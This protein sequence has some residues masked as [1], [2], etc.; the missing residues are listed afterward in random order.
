[1]LHRGLKPLFLSIPSKRFPEQ[2]LSGRR[3]LLR[4]LSLSSATERDV[5]LIHQLS[6][7]CGPSGREGSVSGLPVTVSLSM[8]CRA[9]FNILWPRT[10]AAR[11]RLWNM[12]MFRTAHIYLT[13]VIAFV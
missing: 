9:P 13:A 7:N 4:Q 2:F 8:R 12:E 1:M 3:S 10:R 11:A 5:L 6:A